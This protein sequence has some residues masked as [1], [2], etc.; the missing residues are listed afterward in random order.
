VKSKKSKYEYA[1][2]YF[3]KQSMFL[4]NFSSLASIQTDLDKF[5]TFFQEKF[6]IFFMKI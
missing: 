1:I 2:L 3:T 4:Q 6:K 5:L